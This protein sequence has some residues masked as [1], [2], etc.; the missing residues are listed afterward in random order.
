MPMRINVR[1]WLRIREGM[2]IRVRMGWTGVGLRV[3]VMGLGRVSFRVRI[4]WDFGL[5]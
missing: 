1:I 4:K 2:M 5:R 3:T